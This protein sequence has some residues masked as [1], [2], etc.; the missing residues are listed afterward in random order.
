VD[1]GGAIRQEALHLHGSDAR[2]IT[3]MDHMGIEYDI[4]QRLAIPTNVVF[5]G[6]LNLDETTLGMSPK[7]V[8][9]AST[10]GFSAVDYAGY[11]AGQA[12]EHAADPLELPG[13]ATRRADFLGT[14]RLASA[15]DSQEVAATLTP[16]VR[17]NELLVAHDQHYGY[18]VLNDVALYVRTVRDMI[19]D[20]EATLHA[21]V[22]A[23]V[24]QKVLPKFFSWH[25]DR[26]G[27]LAT[28]L[29]FCVHGEVANGGRGLD[30]EALL[31]EVE[32]D[33]ADRARR[34]DGG[35]TYLP[36]SAGRL[37]RM[38]HARG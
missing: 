18:R 27:L 21:A 5:T 22:D 20:D 37:V 15:A 7:V 6:T 23:C 4:P 32:V 14:L 34:L 38:L 12:T 25:A 28:L 24:L 16:F 29:A 35:E 9:R 19:A 26:G 2:Q 1:E 11:L 3:W 30:V 36:R 31:D 33:P 10:I 13:D 17:L 8:D